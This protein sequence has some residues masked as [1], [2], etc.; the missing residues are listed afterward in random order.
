MGGAT[1]RQWL[2]SKWQRVRRQGTCLGR[3]WRL[4]WQEGRSP[5]G[6]LSPSGP[7]LVRGDDRGRGNPVQRLQALEESVQFLELALTLREL[8]G[9]DG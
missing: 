6:P 9:K 3:R 1:G 8:C 5:G 4:I 2:S 7:H